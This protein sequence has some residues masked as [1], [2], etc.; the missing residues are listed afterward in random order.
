MIMLAHHARLKLGSV[1]AYYVVVVVI[2]VS[3]ILQYLGQLLR[4]LKL[5]QQ[6]RQ[7]G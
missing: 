2:V 3:V 4:E 6:S 7:T 5:L 1:I